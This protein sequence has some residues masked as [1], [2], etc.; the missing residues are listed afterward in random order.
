VRTY[1]EASTRELSDALEREVA[2]I[3]FDTAG[4]VGQ[5]R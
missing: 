2:R 3:V 5:R 1:A 4:G